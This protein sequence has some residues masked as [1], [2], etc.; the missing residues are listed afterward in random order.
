MGQHMKKGRSKAGLLS[1]LLFLV[2]LAA[3]ILFFVKTE[4]N[5]AFNSTDPVTVEIPQ[6]AS[7]S[8]V[9]SRL[10]EAGA[11]RS[12]LLFRFYSRQTGADGSYQY[13]TFSL[14]PGE[15]YAAMIEALQQMQDFRQGVSV[16]IPEGYNVFQI[17]DVM[18]Q[19]GLCTREEF[20]DAADTHEYAVSF[21][22]EISDDP[23]KICRLEGFL[24]PDTYEFFE[25]TGADGVILTMLQ[26]FE[27]KVLTDRRRE[28]LAQSGY[29]LEELVTFASIIQK[30]AANTEEMYNVASV[31]CNRLQPDSGYPRLESC[32]TNNFINDYIQPLYGGS[33]P[34]D[35]REAYDTYHRSGFPVGAI[36]NAGVDAF[37]AAL[38]P[39]DTPYYFFVTDIERTH[40]YGVTPKDHKANIQK[41]L[42]V[43]RT[44]GKDTL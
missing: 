26:N 11:I 24:F 9:A 4:I 14:V 8:V 32:T 30:E 1:A 23:L 22:G 36:A 5:G 12:T 33:V 40:Y 16:T 19:K 35:I 38:N 18:E 3:L 25:D 27:T 43:N 10:K 17:A 2:I 37:D 34:A 7:T 21:M 44:Y 20:L 6:G 39:N 42:A 28:Q 41:A 29:T 13:G 31:F 15:G